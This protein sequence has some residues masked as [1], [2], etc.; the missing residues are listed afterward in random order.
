MRKFIFSAVSDANAG[1]LGSG[2]SQALNKPLSIEKSQRGIDSLRDIAT[3]SNFAEVAASIDYEQII[4][5]I[6]DSVNF[7][8][9]KDEPKVYDVIA[10]K[11]RFDVYF[12][13]CS[14][15][16]IVAPF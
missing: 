12:S 16:F 9:L 1:S 11:V 13:Y 14:R 2:D 6:D 7:V 5:T 8:P 3:N 4:K 15:K 10:F